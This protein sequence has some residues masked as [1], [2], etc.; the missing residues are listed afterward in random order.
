MLMYMQLPQDTKF[1]L[2]GANDNLCPISEETFGNTPNIVVTFTLAIPSFDVPISVIS[3]MQDDAL[4][5][6]SLAQW[7]QRQTGQ[8]SNAES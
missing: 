4:K 8:R 3:S 5:R 1:S 6:L 2:N 7:G